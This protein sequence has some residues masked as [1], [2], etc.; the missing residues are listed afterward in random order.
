MQRDTFSQSGQLHV[1][2]KTA[3][4]CALELKNFVLRLDYSGKSLHCMV[5]DDLVPCV[6]RAT[7]AMVLTI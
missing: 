2:K 4:V 5:A 1:R 6:A 7:T 3:R